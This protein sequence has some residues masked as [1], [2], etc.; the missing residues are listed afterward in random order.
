MSHANAGQEGTQVL[1]DWEVQTQFSCWRSAATARSQALLLQALSQPPPLLSLLIT[2]RPRSLQT[3][4]PSIT[5]Q[6]ALPKVCL[7]L[8][9]NLPSCFWILHGVVMSLPCF[10]RATLCLNILQ[11]ML[12]MAMAI[13]PVQLCMLEYKIQTGVKHCCLSNMMSHSQN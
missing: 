13:N 11:H 7:L 5:F 6:P 8:P 2:P 3:S 1:S 10:L 4:Q 9:G 12:G